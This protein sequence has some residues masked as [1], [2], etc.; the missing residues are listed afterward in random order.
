MT[1][2]WSGYNARHSS[3]RTIAESFVAPTNFSGMAR[4]QNSIFVGPRGSGKTTILKVLT[5]EGLHHLLQRQDLPPEIRELTIDYLPVYIPADAAWKSDAVAMQGAVHSEEARR[6]ILNGIY[7]D[8]TLHWLVQAIE[9]ARTIA[10]EHKAPIRPAWTAAFN[11]DQELTLARR[12]SAAWKL[13]RIQ[14]SLVGLKL[15]LNDRIN[16]LRSPIVAP[17][18]M[19]LQ[20]ALASP[21]LDI[22]QMLKSS[23]DAFADIH[24]TLKWSF[25][26]DEMEI[27]PRHLVSQLYEHLRSWDQRAVLKFSLFP[28]VDFYTLEQ[29]SANA[30]IGPG[31]GPDFTFFPLTNL[32]HRTHSPLTGKLIMAECAKRGVDVGEFAAY[33]NSSTSIKTGTRVFDGMRTGRNHNRL[34]RDAFEQKLDRGLLRFLKERSF[35]SAN[36]LTAIQGENERAGAIRKIAPLVEF[37]SYYMSE[38]RARKKSG[39]RRNSPK[40]FN[41]Y[42]GFG[43]IIALTENNPRAVKYYVN[44]LLDLMK[45]KVKSSTAQN[46]VIGRNVDRFCALVASQL[47]PKEAGSE[48]IQNALTFSDQLARV[49]VREVLDDNFKPEPPLS[50]IFKSPPEQVRRIVEVAVNAGALVVDS[51]RTIDQLIFD[52]GGQRF[53]LSHCFA[54]RHPLPTI[55][56]P[57]IIL[58]RLPAIE[59][60]FGKQAD[61]FAWSERD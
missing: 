48:P 37:R 41:Y 50:V 14:T 53:R 56:G 4:F 6:H 5:P 24:P 36:Q 19:N 44:D 43:Q 31:D 35:T 47:V 49:F 32:F 39:S 52:I 17:S 42:H 34:F 9:S 7:V 46:D 18:K 21:T 25:N 58:T 30:E 20:A 11:E 61:L 15:A 1:G 23:M 2:E 16:T 29:K 22:F 38:T 54:P 3:L 59:P 55:A 27:A 51:N 26:F 28:Y 45:A 60:L 10:Q 12:L 57:E 13:N 40:G 8:H 33:L